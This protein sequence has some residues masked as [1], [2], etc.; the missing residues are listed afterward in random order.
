MSHTKTTVINGKVY[1]G[2]EAYGDDQYIVYCYDPSQDKWTSLPPLPVRWFGLGQVYGKLVSV[3]GWKKSTGNEIKDIYTYDERSQK[4]KQII[5]PMPTARQYPGVLSLQLALVVAGGTSASLIY[6]NTV[7]IFKPDASQWYRTDLL[8]T[9]CC[10][11][12]L[13]AIGDIC[14]ALGG[15]NGSHLNQ[16]LYASVDDLL[17]NAVPAKQTTHSGS[18]DTRSAWKT[19]PNTPTYRPAVAVVAGK[20]LAIGGRETSKDGADVKDVYMFSPSTNS[21]IYISELP[22]APRSF[23]AAAVLSSIEILVI[24][25]WV[26]HGRVNTVY[27]GTLTVL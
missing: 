3:G 5:S 7:D 4:W 6:S 13:V 27:K 11:I 24:G 16:A 1:Y 8:P 22:S 10:N 15:Y 9:A 18:S 17:G 23:T 21:W 25:G 14:Y 2:G 12:S 19:L 26:G 20:L